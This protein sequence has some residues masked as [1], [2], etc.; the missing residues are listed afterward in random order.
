MI[1]FLSAH[2]HGDHHPA[3]AIAINW[4]APVAVLSA[5]MAVL[6]PR[7]PNGLLVIIGALAFL[8]VWGVFGALASVLAHGARKVRLD[9]SSLGLERMFYLLCIAFYG[10][11]ALIDLLLWC[12]R[13]A[14]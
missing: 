11:L 3:R 13:L 7:A 10:V 2:W 6:D 14:G 9:R 8:N 4:V 12:I 5:S 1:A